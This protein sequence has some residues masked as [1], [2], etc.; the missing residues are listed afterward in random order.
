MCNNK[1]FDKPTRSEFQA[2]MREALRTAKERLR[3]KT[4]G[5]RMQMVN[6]RNRRNLWSDE[7]SDTEHID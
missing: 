7:R 4:R 6:N 2:H 3:S 1:H 5:H